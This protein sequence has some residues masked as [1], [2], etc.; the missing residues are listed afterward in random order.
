M[1]VP[2]HDGWTVTAVGGAVPEG[3]VGVRLPATVPGSVH[4]DLMAAGLIPDPYLDENELKVAWVGRVDWRY[5]TVFDW[6]GEGCETDLVALGLDTMATIELNGVAIART[7]NMHRSYRFPVR[8]KLQ[9]G[10]NALAITF[11]AGL[12]AAEAA[13]VAA[14]TASARQRAS[15][16]RASE[17]GLQL[18]VGLGSRPGDSRH[19]AAAVP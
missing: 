16:Q 11:A 10:P 8:D 18:R 3:L 9:V 1:H 4:L 7:S 5:E 19:L 14:R 2:L 12:T 6:D 17:D 13:S 15:V